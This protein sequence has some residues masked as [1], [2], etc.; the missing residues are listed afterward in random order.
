M[1]LAR[2]PYYLEKDEW[3]QEGY[4]GREPTDIAPAY[5]IKDYNDIFQEYDLLYGVTRRI[6]PER[7]VE[8]RK[9]INYDPDLIEK[10]LK[11]IYTIEEL[12]EYRIR[13]QE[14][15]WLPIKRALFKV[16]FFMLL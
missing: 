15:E 4:I 5:V 14:K 3:N 2:L 8:M 9:R 13:L 10:E 7:F 12:D 16:S 11:E 6:E 1:D